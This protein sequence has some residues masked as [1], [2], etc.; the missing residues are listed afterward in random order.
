MRDFSS[1]KP[2]RPRAFMALLALSVISC[3]A[4]G[5]AQQQPDRTVL[6]QPVATGQTPQGA[7]SKSAT[8]Y[9]ARIHYL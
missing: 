2:S 6:T 7:S 9:G 8:V 1:G 5:L 4:T 3:A